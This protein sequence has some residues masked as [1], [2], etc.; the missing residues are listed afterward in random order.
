MPGLCI[1]HTQCMITVTITTSLLLLI[2]TSAVSELYRSFWGNKGETLTLFAGGVGD[3]GHRSFQEEVVVE[4][5][6]MLSWDEAGSCV[7]LGPEMSA[8]EGLPMTP[9]PVSSQCAAWDHR[10]GNWAVGPGRRQFLLL[11]SPVLELPFV[12][13]PKLL[14]YSVWMTLCSSG[15]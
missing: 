9:M 7:L 5:S 8:Q 15:V 10:P 13:P 1:V 4:Q 2:L 12:L 3:E 14:I 6:L 11:H